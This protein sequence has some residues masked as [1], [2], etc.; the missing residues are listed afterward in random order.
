[1]RMAGRIDRIDRRNDGSLEIRDYKTG[2]SRDYSISDPFRQGRQLQPLLYCE[3]LRRGL[4]VRGGMEK[5]SRFS[6]HFLSPKEEG[7]VLSFEASG[8]LPGL[9]IV[10]KLLSLMAAGCFPFAA[11]GGD[12]KYSDYRPLFGDC[13]LAARAAELK[14]VSNSV[15]APWRELSLPAVFEDDEDG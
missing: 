10:E 4:E 7:R 3:M 12:M 14:A 13:R 15:L 9:S 8:L 5:V 1:M 6:Y 2:G 11:R